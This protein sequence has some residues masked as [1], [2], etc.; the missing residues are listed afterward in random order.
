MF[1]SNCEAHSE[2]VSNR[3]LL[4][5]GTSSRTYSLFF[6]HP[7]CMASATCPQTRSQAIFA[8]FQNLN[9]LNWPR[10]SSVFMVK[11]IALRCGLLCELEVVAH[12]CARAAVVWTTGFNWISSF[13]VAHNRETQSSLVDKN[14]LMPR[15]RLSVFM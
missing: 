14:F 10:F 1:L 9:C 2:R 7:A 15:A 6:L 11:R 5:L 4:R 3:S 8:K 13:S 12:T